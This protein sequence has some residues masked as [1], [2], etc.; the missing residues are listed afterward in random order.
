MKSLPVVEDWQ[1]VLIEEFFDSFEF[2]AYSLWVVISSA[3]REKV[4]R[5]RRSTVAAF[6]YTLTVV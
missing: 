6:Y 3:T 2:Y 1:G 5:L 4:L